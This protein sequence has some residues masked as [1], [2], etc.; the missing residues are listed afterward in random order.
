MATAAVTGATGYIGGRLVPQLLRAGHKVRVL[1]RRAEALRDVP[2]R[3][4]VT[5]VEGD[6]T[7]PE[8]AR[9]LCEGAD[10]A[11][12]LVHSMTSDRSFEELDERCAEVLGTAA[13]EAGVDHIVYLAGLHP[14]TSAGELSAHLRSRVHV[15]EVLESSGVPTLTLQAGLVIGSGSASFEMIR[16]LTDV[17]PVMPA[18]KWVLNQIQPIAV[19]DALHYLTRAM[20]IELS[21]SVRADIGGPDVHTYAQLMKIYARTAGLNEPHVIALPVLTP[22][23][24]AQWVNLVTPIPRTLAIPLVESLQHDCVV[25]DQIINDIIEPPEGGLTDYETSVRL[26]LDKISADRVETTWAAAHP[27]DVPSESLPSDPEWTGRSVLVDERERLSTA[28][29][30]AVFAVIE[31]IGGETGYFSLSRAWALRGLADKLVGGVGMGRGRRSRGE[32][33]L[34]DTLDWWRVEELQRGRLLRLRA[35]MKVPGQA[36]LEFTVEP[37]GTGSRYRQ[38]A[39]FFPRGL[40]GRAYWLGVTP[41]HAIIF[42]KMAARILADAEQASAED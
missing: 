18:P 28:S 20:D 21:S 33:A 19:R 37:E 42:K 27:L 15:G 40:A 14:D 41:F 25:K 36:W 39:I 30:E 17:L 11:Y 8:A 29:P 24:A 34:G 4:E 35:E 6:L 38:R 16:H 5:V 7:D 31:G 2:W 23:L 13:K 3:D 10:T 22:W 9:D 32:L 1:T 12:Y 26:A